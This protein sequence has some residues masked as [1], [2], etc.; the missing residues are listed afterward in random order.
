MPEKIAQGIYQAGEGCASRSVDQKTA[1]SLHI[2]E[3]EGRL[4]SRMSPDT[5][6]RQ[7]LM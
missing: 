1:F 2:Y 6:N 4:I 3:P 5:G 7:Y